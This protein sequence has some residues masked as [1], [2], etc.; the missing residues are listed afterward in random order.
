M[1]TKAECAFFSDLLSALIC[2]YQEHS[3]L[4]YSALQAHCGNSSALSISDS[5]QRIVVIIIHLKKKRKKKDPL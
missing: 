2:L 1:Q 3:F 5:E 4:F